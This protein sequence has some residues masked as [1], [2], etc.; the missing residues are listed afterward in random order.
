MNLNVDNCPSCGAVYRINVRN[1]CQAC[2][3]RLDDGLNRCLDH[4]WKCPDST[5]EQLSEATGVPSSAIA[6]LMKE[7]KLSKAYVKLTYPCE[8]CGSPIRDNRLCR[9]CMHSFKEIAQQLK[10][11][12]GFHPTGVYFNERLKK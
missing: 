2:S 8:S 3:A 7:G 9:T 5:T 1:L 10:S 6:K 12:I 11:K 4:L